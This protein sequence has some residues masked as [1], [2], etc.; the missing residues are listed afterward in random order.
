MCCV[1]AQTQ[2]RRTRQ[3][4]GHVVSHQ[5]NCWTAS[6]SNH[7][8]TT[9]LTSATSEPTSHLERS[10]SYSKPSVSARH[11]VAPAKFWLFEMYKLLLFRD[12]VLV[13]VELFFVSNLLQSFHCYF[14]VFLRLVIIICMSACCSK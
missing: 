6:F 14:R 12:F 1:L 5:G 3:L 10:A 4:D 13:I 8:Q 9:L 2:C 7:M 11:K